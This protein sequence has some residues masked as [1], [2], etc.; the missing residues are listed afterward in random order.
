MSHSTGVQKA[1]D[2]TD[3]DRRYVM[4][5]CNPPCMAKGVRSNNPSN[6]GGTTW[7]C[8]WN[9]TGKFK[10]IGDPPSCGFSLFDCNV[11]PRGHLSPD[12][13]EWKLAWTEVEKGMNRLREKRTQEVPSRGLALNSSPGSVLGK[14]HISGDEQPCSHAQHMR[15]LVSG[16]ISPEQPFSHLRARWFLVYRNPNAAEDHRSLPETQRGQDNGKEKAGTMEG[17]DG[18]SDTARLEARITILTEM[19]RAQQVQLEEKEMHIQALQQKYKEQSN[20]LSSLKG[21]IDAFEKA[22]NGESD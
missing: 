19:V 18:A 3:P 20:Q 7:I 8:R 9:N 4:C 14:R 21:D 10:Q 22:M 13:R 17:R 16:N 12:S 2:D 15:F 11:N 1:V 6:L 5:K